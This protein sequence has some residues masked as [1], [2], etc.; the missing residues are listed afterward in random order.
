LWS[1]VCRPCQDSKTRAG[2]GSEER[3]A[4]VWPSG[5]EEWRRRASAWQNPGDMQNDTKNL[6]E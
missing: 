3:V 4:R 1:S 5:A 2:T 6:P